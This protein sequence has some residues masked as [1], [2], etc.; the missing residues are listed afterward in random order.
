M[1]VAQPPCGSG[2]ERSKEIS[3]LNRQFFAITH[4]PPQC[5]L[6]GVSLF[7]IV[8]IALC[9][10]SMTGGLKSKVS[11]RPTHVDR[12]GVINYKGAVAQA[13]AGACHM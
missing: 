8:L 5:N 2:A 11:V 3:S 13:C 10:Y 6:L 7:T 9:A 4:N 12:V 1:L